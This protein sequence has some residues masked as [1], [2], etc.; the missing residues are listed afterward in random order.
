LQCDVISSY[1]D[2]GIPV[3][4]DGIENPCKLLHEISERVR[5]GIWVE[6]CFIYTN[7]SWRLNYCVGDEVSTLSPF[8]FYQIN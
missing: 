6:D 5:R 3:D 8:S 4:E 1:L 2:D 7:S